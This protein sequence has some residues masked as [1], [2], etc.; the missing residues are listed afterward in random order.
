MGLKVFIVSLL[1]GQQGKNLKIYRSLNIVHWVKVIL[2]I[3]K[4]I[5]AIEFDVKYIRLKLQI[6]NIR[7]F[8][9]NIIYGKKIGLN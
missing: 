9:K 1:R 5:Q 6:L 3:K 2:R 7:T 4:I 8:D